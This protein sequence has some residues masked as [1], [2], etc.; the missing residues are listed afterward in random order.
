MKRYIRLLKEK[1]YIGV[2]V[3]LVCACVGSFRGAYKEEKTFWVGVTQEDGMLAEQ[4]GKTAPDLIGVIPLAA[5]QMHGKNFEYAYIYAFR[6]VVLYCL[7]ML[8][9]LPVY[10]FRIF[11]WVRHMLSAEEKEGE[12]REKLFIDSDRDPKC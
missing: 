5:E 10:H 6:G 11:V 7:L 9:Y 4:A 3:I 1:M 2:M 8:F 12:K